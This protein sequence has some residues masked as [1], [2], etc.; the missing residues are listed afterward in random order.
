VQGGPN[1]VHSG[2]GQVEK[3]KALVR[4][5]I[6]EGV[7]AANFDL[8]AE[9][10][11]PGYVRHRQSMP[12][13]LREMHGLEA[14]KHFLAE[15]HATFPDYHEEIQLIL[16]EGKFVAF[17]GRGTGAQQGAL[18]PLPPTQKRTDIAILVI[19]RFEG[20][21][22]AETWTSWDNLAAMMQLGHYPPAPAALP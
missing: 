4:R 1:V 18:G 19:H 7:N 10:L 14:M 12:P 13:P 20:A 8:F 9:A 15:N 6:E 11:T 2:C 21:R 5:I 3:N 22:I 17:V 16:G